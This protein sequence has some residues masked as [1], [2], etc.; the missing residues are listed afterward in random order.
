MWK[1]SRR[2]YPLAATVIYAGRGWTRLTEAGLGASAL[3][4]YEI[5]RRYIYLSHP[6]T[7][8][9]IWAS[10]TTRPELEP[11]EP[12]PEPQRNDVVARD[13]PQSPPRHRS[14]SDLE[15]QRFAAGEAARLGARGRR[16]GGAGRAGEHQ[17]HR[18]L[19]P[20]QQAPGQYMPHGFDAPPVSLC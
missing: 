15:P 8:D 5:L 4:R 9:C 12:E 7:G 17:Y 13:C 6:T 18:R 11:A 14:L 3:S 1:V 16:T 2:C 20:S 10:T 19:S